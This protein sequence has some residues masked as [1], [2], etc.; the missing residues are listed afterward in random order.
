M[1]PVIPKAPKLTT[2][3][4]KE[5][6]KLLTNQGFRRLVQIRRDATDSNKIIQIVLHE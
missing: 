4:V 1:P 6:Q 2:I 3:T 5:A